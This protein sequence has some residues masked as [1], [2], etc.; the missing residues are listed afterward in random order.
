[1]YHNEEHKHDGHNSENKLLQIRWKRNLKCLHVRDDGWFIEK[2]SITRRELHNLND[3][4]ADDLS[5]VQIIECGVG[6]FE[7]AFPC[8]RVTKIEDS[9]FCK[10]DH[11]G[12]VL[13]GSCTI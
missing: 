10:L 4:P 7:F 11:L 12:K 8:N 13:S 5:M 2:D 1:M 9:S 6:F 3:C